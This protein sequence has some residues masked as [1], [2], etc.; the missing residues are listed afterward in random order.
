MNH[1]LRFFL[2]LVLALLF[3]AAAVAAVTMTFLTVKDAVQS[4]GSLETFE[5]RVRHYSE[6][7]AV[8][9]NGWRVFRVAHPIALHFGM[10]ALSWLLTFGCAMGLRSLLRTPAATYAGPLARA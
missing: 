2:G 1:A 6:G 7:L 8:D 3:A 4:D 10:L 9:A 5:A